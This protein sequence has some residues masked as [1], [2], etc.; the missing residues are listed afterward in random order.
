MDQSLPQAG[1]G[2]DEAFGR[3]VLPEVELL[4]RAATA[5]TGRAADAE[6]L[7]RD[8]LLRA[9]REVQ[10]HTEETRSGG[11]APSRAWL[12]DLMRAAWGE[13][14]AAGGG[15]AP[16]RQHPW[17]GAGEDPRADAVFQQEVARAAAGLPTLQRQVVRLVDEAELTYAEAARLLGV[18]E[19][20]AAD[21]LRRGRRRIRARLVAAGLVAR[22]GGRR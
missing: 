9:H 2:R 18:T 4:L 16:E 21:E 12:L 3:I 6:A 22:R 17:T 11:G 10:R 14:K 1:A 19:A 15:A 7:V 5:L 8:T 13:R 20:A